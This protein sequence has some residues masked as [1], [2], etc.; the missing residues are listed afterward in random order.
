[1][2][3]I[4]CHFDGRTLLNYKLLSKTCYTL[5]E[6]VL[7]FNK[8]WKKICLEE[9]PKKYLFDLL[10]KQF[11]TFIQLNSLSEIQFERLYKNWL[12]LQK[13]VFDV[14]KIGQHNFLGLHG[15]NRIVSHKLDVRVSFL[16][17]SFLFSVQKNHIGKYGVKKLT[18]ELVLSRTL[19]VLNPKYK[20]NEENEFILI[21]RTSL[22]T[23]P[24]H[25]TVHGIYMEYPGILIDVIMNSYTNK[26]CWIREAGFECY[27]NINSCIISNHLCQSASNNLFTSV[28]YEII[29]GQIDINTI[30]IHGIFD[31]S[32]KQVKS[33][34]NDK[35]MGATS[36]HIYTNI[37]IIGTNNGYLL[38]YRLTCWDDLIN[39]KENNLLF[40]TRLDSCNINKLEIMDFKNIQVII[41]STD[42]SVYFIKIN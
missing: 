41:V 20:T 34:L 6:N 27:S 38:A 28:I 12:R 14:T 22:N 26:C 24:L 30:F 19:V 15:I 4:I 8:L 9:I 33:W 11:D 37:L 40:E 25:N 23:C 2:E 36:V 32:C 29:I 21:D 16:E 42:S 13:P 5:V 35:Y 10:S 18:S 1:M 3:K 7:R 39:I 31:S 17:Y